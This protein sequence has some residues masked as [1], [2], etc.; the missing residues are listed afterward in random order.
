MASDKSCCGSAVC[1]CES[2]ESA[3]LALADGKVFHGVAI[4][5]SGITSGEVVFNTALSGYQEILTDPSYTNQM[6]TFTC[7]HIGNVGCNDED[8][9]SSCVHASGIIVRQM[10]K[11]YSNYRAT[12]SLRDYLVRNNV[13]GIGDIDTRSLVLHLRTYGAQMGVI[14]TGIEHSCDELVD[15][16]RALPSMEGQDLTTR[17]STKVP[18]EWNQSIWTQEGGFSVIS[19]EEMKGRPHVVVMDFGVKFNILRL[20]VAHGFRVTVVPASY[21]VDDIEALLPDCVFLSNGPGDPAAVTGAIHTVR[22]LVGAYPLYGICLGHQILALSQGAKTFKLKFG[23]RGGNHPVRN[24]H[25][26]NVEITVQNHGF[27]VCEDGMPAHVKLTHINL[28]DRTIEGIEIPE[29]RAFS[30]QYHPEASPG[31]WDA[32]YL[33]KQFRDMVG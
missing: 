28:N 17:V 2:V 20:L 32:R 14:A 18:Y 23:H 9:E 6:L 31:P 1:G 3:T 8:V 26:G 21:G 15:M 33:F 29:A 4:G 5:A 11:R 22:N 12:M 10:A 30:V 13:V 16:A 7:P 24:E 19:N 25:A 27:A